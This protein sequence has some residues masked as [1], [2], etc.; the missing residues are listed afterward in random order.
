MAKAKRLE[1]LLLFINQKKQFTLKELADEF[2]VSP[3]TIQRD[4]LHLIDRGLPILSEYGP[5]GGYTL[6]REKILPPIGFSESEAL[7]FLFALQS[8]GVSDSFPYSKEA[9]SVKEKLMN[10]LSDDGIKQLSNIE[11]KWQGKMLLSDQVPVH[12]PLF[13]QAAIEQRVITVE[14]ELSGDLRI[15]ILQPIGIIENGYNWYSPCYNPTDKTVHLL[16]LKNIKT[17]AIENECHPLTGNTALPVSQWN[18]LVS[19]LEKLNL[20]VNLN[21]NGANKALNHPVLRKDTKLSSKRSGQIE[22]IIPREALP[23]YAEWIWAFGADAYVV[24]PS[25]LVDYLRAKTDEMAQIYERITPA[26]KV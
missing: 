9:Q 6:M 11:K 2:K 10:F 5:H 8:L 20:H 18:E 21:S 17:A 1:Q 7:S 14:Y 12:L 3:R 26:L 24:S 16:N 19:P 13:F 4:L 22:A 23:L 25:E 15:S